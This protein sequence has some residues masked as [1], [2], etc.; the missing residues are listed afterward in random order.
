MKRTQER[1]CRLELSPPRRGVGGSLDPRV[2]CR[3]PW[4]SQDFGTPP[5]RSAYW[6][7]PDF[8]PA[9]QDLCRGNDL[10]S[11]IAHRTKRRS[12]F[13]RC[14]SRSLSRDLERGSLLGQG[15]AGS[16]TCPSDKVGISSVQKNG[17]LSGDEHTIQRSADHRWHALQLR[18]ISKKSGDLRDSSHRKRFG[19]LLPS[20]TQ[21]ARARKAPV[22]CACRLHARCALLHQGSGEFFGGQ[23]RRLSSSG[24]MSPTSFPSGSATTA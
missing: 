21:S 3:R 18:R 23:L 2:S 7:A 8:R 4:A 1:T 19:T 15:S 10:G 20:R 9:H 12:P 13:A 11:A 17:C 24:L 16:R 22:S 6:R 14:C 5:N